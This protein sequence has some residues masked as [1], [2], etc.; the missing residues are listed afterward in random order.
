MLTSNVRNFTN[1][2]TLYKRA[3]LKYVQTKIIVKNRNM[4]D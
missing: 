4:L 1:H 2:F 3:I